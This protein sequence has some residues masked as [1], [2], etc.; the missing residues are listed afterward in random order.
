MTM[1]AAVGL[2]WTN[3][4]LPKLKTTDNPLKRILN[5]VEESMVASV[6]SLGIGFSTVTAGLVADKI[7]KKLALVIYGIP[8]L[9]TDVI[10]IFAT[11]IEFYYVARFCV[12]IGVGC[13]WTVTPLYT[14]EISTDENRGFT[15]IF[16]LIL[17]NCA[18]L[19]LYALGPYVS[20]PIISMTTL[21]YTVGFMVLCPLFVPESPYYYAIC[22]KPE[23]AEA[24]LKKLRRTDD[25]KEEFAVVMQSVEQSKVR[26]THEESWSQIFKSKAIIRSLGIVLTLLLFTQFTGNVPLTLFLQDIFN[27]SKSNLPSHICVI[28]VTVVQL[29]S[30]LCVSK[31]VDLVNRR[32]LLYISQIGTCFALFP[33]GTYFF[34]LERNYNMD[35]FFWL[36]VTCVVMYNIFYNIGIGP[37]VFVMAGELFPT[38]HLRTYLSGIAF[39]FYIIVGYTMSW[40]PYIVHKFGIATPLFIFTGI[41]LLSLIFIYFC[42]PETRGKSFLE[43]QRMLEEGRL[44]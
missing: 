22:K 40:F 2:A 7:G 41:T 8:M 39:T 20:I 12:G 9:A 6:L 18:Q 44:K 35:A 43:I 14:A 5:P 34:F 38:N 30:L 19:F 15:S 1:T 16:L 10:F 24:S 27:A 42:V 4:C 23:K 21:V 28:I 25:V 13:V 31:V 33:V 26:K 17:T 36:P 32:I 3:P 29:I 37:L 11:K